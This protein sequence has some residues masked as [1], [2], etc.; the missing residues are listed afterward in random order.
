MGYRWYES[1]G[2]DPLFA[3]GHGLSYTDF[4]VQPAAG[5]AASTDGNE[6]DPHPVPADQHR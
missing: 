2:I 6:G 1:Q 5:H 4:D 3:F